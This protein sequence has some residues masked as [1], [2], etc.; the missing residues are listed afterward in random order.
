MMAAATEQ[1][2]LHRLQF[3][4]ARCREPELAQAHT[5]LR[6]LQLGDPSSC[7]AVAVVV[8]GTV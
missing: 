1:H 5:P 2:Q 3:T 6:A 4:H 8:L 7:S